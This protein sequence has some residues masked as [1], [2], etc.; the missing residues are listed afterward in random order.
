MA[1]PNGGA[2]Y[3]FCTTCLFELLIVMEWVFVLKE[4]IEMDLSPS[5]GR[6]KP[7]RENK[8]DDVGRFSCTARHEYNTYQCD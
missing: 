2:T 5:G 3:S 4:G 1:L 8:K 6:I 7:T